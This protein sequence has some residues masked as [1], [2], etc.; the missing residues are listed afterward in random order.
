MS[1][2]NYDFVS[3][4]AIST[5]YHRSHSRISCYACGF[6]QMAWRIIMSD[7][8]LCFLSL[9]EDKDG[10]NFERLAIHKAW[11]GLNGRQVYISGVLLCILQ[12]REGRLADR[13]KMCNIHF[14]LGWAE[15]RST[16]WVR[17]FLSIGCPTY[18]VKKIWE[19]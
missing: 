16:W 19:M 15:A 11:C 13:Q 2:L 9:P 18:F 1:T 5:R 17:Y 4:I 6:G 7:H 8:F 12:E 14:L 10:M 3:K